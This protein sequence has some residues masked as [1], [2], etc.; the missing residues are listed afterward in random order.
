LKTVCYRVAHHFIVRSDFAKDKPDVVA[1]ALAV[2]F[3]A[4]VWMK[5]HPAQAVE[6]LKQYNEKNGVLLSQASLERTSE[7]STT[8]TLQEELKMFDRSAG[9]ALVD[10]WMN[11][12]SS[13]LVSTGTLGAV[14]DP[15]A[16]LSAVTPHHL[17][18]FSMPSR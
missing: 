2:Y 16:Y 1:K 17:H 6:Y 7:R 12:L 4:V 13:Y 18:F 10:K 11:D 9:L 8:F 14:Q 5:K 15:K 3:R